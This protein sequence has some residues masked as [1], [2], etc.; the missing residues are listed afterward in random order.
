MARGPGKGKTNNPK[1]RTKGSPNR[2]TKEAKELLDNILFGRIDS[3][4]ET[5]DK[6]EAKDPAKYIEA[7]TRLLVYVLPKKSD[8]TTGGDKI[9]I[10][11]TRNGS[12]N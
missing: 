2:T 4:N 11:F 1:G 12:E 9:N 8:L 7:V 6:L 5:L 3:I 10:T